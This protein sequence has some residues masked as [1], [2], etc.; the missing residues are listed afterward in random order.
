MKNLPALMVLGFRNLK[1]SILSLFNIL[2]CNPYRLMVK[3]NNRCNY[4]CKTCGIWN[5]DQKTTLSK[6]KVEKIAEKYKG[7]IYFLSITGGEPFL[8]EERLLDLINEIKKKNKLLKRISINTNCSRPNSV[9]RVVNQALTTF[10]DLKID[11]GLHY[12]PNKKWGAE[13]TGVEKA[14][15]NYEKLK[16]ILQKIEKNSKKRLSFYEMI[17]V[18]KKRDFEKISGGD[19]DLWLNFAVKNEFYNNE[20]D[21]Y[22]E[23]IKAQEKIEIINNFTGENKSNISFLNKLY[24]KNLKKVIKRKRKRRCFAGINRIFVDEKGE[25]FICSRGLKSRKEMSSS[26]CEACWTACESNFDLLPYFF[27]NPINNKHVKD[28]E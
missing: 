18:S 1:I 12:I 10:P 22:I 21:D 6:N 11:I 2:D 3:I 27:L 17:T 5:E 7:K 14:R 23:T 4:R 25:E 16:S 26:R 9:K 8:E 24:L 19:S 13:K 28:Y 20:N 15:Q